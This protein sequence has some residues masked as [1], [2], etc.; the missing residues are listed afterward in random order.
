[1]LVQPENST[2]F[3]Y[4]L[5]WWRE[6]RLLFRSEKCPH[7]SRFYLQQHKV[8]S[9]HANSIQLDD[10]NSSSEYSKEQHSWQRILYALCI[11]QSTQSTHTLLSRVCVK[12][13]RVKHSLKR[14]YM[15]GC[16]EVGPL[17][18]Q[19]LGEIQRI[20]LCSTMKRRVAQLEN[21]NDYPKML[22]IL[23]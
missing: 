5:Q 4:I 18:N 8:G 2:K 11:Q 20:V 15:I 12:R 17:L 13:F 22:Y 21:K 19:Q 6:Y 1:M 10:D 14:T 3:A 9:H 7:Q 23:S 16:M